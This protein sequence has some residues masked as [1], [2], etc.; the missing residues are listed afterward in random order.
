MNKEEISKAVLIYFD[1]HGRI[2]QKD[3]ENKIVDTT[4][5]TNSEI[6]ELILGLEASTQLAIYQIHKT[7]MGNPTIEKEKA[8]E[9]MRH[10]LFYMNDDAFNAL[11]RFSEWCV[12]KG[13]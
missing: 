10:N 5:L 12:A 8:K 6:S 2:P 11:Y 7:F 3:I 4:S 9:T 13:C 1:H